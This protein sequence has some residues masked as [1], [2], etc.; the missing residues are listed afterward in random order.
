MTDTTSRLL[1][2]MS[3][4]QT[5]RTWTGGQLAER[6]EVT[7]RTIR[8]D[9]ERLR[10]LGYLVHATPG[11]AGGYRLDAGAALP[12]LLL[13]DEEAVAVAIGLRTGAGGSVSGIEESSLRALVKLE[14][15]L[16]SRLRHRLRALAAA[17][18]SVPTPAPPVDADALTRIATAIRD[19]EQ[20]R[21]DY[22]GFDG[23]RSR[24]RAEPHRL[25]HARARWYV[26]AWDVDRD[27]WRSFRVDRASLRTP[28]GPRFSPRAEPPGGLVALVES[29]LATATWAYRATAV[30]QAPAASI[31][32]RLPPG[33][34]VDP[35]DDETCRVHVGSDTARQ[36]ALWL[37]MLDAEFTVEGSPELNEHLLAVADRY[38]RAARG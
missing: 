32:A 18:A 24:R 26:V 22:T 4:L 33:I 14:Q 23:T 6:L 36:L 25:V 35:V 11:V 17:T 13:D 12:P 3:L 9:V 28:N 7:P 1:R 31:A 20:L 30:V 34:V 38:R 27:A 16:P 8:N 19:H 10:G 15:V 2:L 5:R 37:G 29:A 21:F